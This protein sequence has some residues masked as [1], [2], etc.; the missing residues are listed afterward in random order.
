[1]PLWIRKAFKK[2]KE[3]VRDGRFKEINNNRKSG[4]FDLC[5]FKLTLLVVKD[6]LLRHLLFQLA[7]KET[8]C[9]RF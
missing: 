7:M 6:P 9:G 3:G 1:M 8:P 2:G 4:I 5:Y